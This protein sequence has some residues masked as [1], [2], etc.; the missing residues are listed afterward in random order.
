MQ[1]NTAARKEHFVYSFVD[2][3]VVSGN[4]VFWRSILHADAKEM[5]RKKYNYFNAIPTL[6]VQL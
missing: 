5:Q 1:Q 6:L 3:N 2:V 4:E